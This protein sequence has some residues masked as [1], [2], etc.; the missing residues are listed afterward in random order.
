VGHIQAGRS[1]FSHGGCSL[2][3]AYVSRWY[4]SAY[5]VLIAIASVIDVPIAR[6]FASVQ[7]NLLIRLGSLWRL[8]RNAP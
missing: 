5:A 1:R 3:A 2:T 4:A 8:R 6:G 7:L